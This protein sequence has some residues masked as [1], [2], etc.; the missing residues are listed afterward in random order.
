MFGVRT[1]PLEEAAE[2]V[3]AD[4]ERRGRPD[5]VVSAGW[6]RG[7]ALFNRGSL[8]DGRAHDEA[9]WRAAHDLGDP[10]LGW[11][12][13]Q[14]P[15][16]RHT[17]YLL[18]PRSGRAWC[19]RGLG[20]PRF[21]DTG[22]SHDTLVDQLG[23]ALLTAGDRDAARDVVAGLP[24]TALSRRLLRLRDG[25]TEDAE[26]EWAAAMGADEAAGDLHDAAVNAL[27]LA[28][29]RE[30]LGDLSGALDCLRR[31]AEIGATGPQVPMELAARAELARLLASSDGDAAGSELDRCREILA[32]G[33]DYR[34][35]TGRVHLAAARLHRVRGEDDD[36]ERA[37]AAART[38]TEAMGLPWPDDPFHPTSTPLPRPSS[39]V[40]P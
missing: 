6:A 9:T 15:A 21:A 36:A 29:A 30:L 26:A 28:E 23:M 4:A 39:T 27:W 8:A 14:A 40:A 1:R 12:A 2:A 17:I 35:R 31:A 37:L 24:V 19:R 22:H 11:S 5:L 18:D 33:E 16:I 13:A 20:Q 3:L 32:G 10:Y 25:L 7:W 38:V 34:G